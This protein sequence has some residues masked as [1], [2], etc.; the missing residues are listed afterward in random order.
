MGVVILQ[1]RRSSWS[2]TFALVVALACLAGTA[3][4]QQT[5]AAARETARTLMDEGDKH[6]DAGNLKA[7][8]KSYEA[9]DTIMKVPTT[10]LEVARAQAALGMLVEARES[11]ARIAQS[12]PKAGEPAPFAAARK[13][14][15]TL[16][17]ELGARIPSV[18]ISINGADPT[19]PL[20]ITIDGANI[21]L[22]EASSGRRV[23][24]GRH[25]IVV[26]SGSVEKQDEINIAERTSKTLTFDL[27]D[28]RTNGTTWSS[29]APRDDAK[30]RARIL[31]FGGFGLAIVGVGVGTVTGAM[32]LSKTSDLEDSCP[33][34]RCPPG[35]QGEI[36]SAKTLGTVSTVAFVAGGIG[37]GAGIVGLVL[38]MSHSK[39][40]PM[41]EPTAIGGV[42]L[43]PV[44]APSYAGLGG[45]F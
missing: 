28:K 23:N 44:L 43:A 32:S 2:L 36:D 31:M 27:D 26:K 38:S 39:N 16:S 9:A 24:P 22:G 34:N 41:G 45:T 8:L 11:L 10:G 21:A 12:T 18:T 37:L 33:A 1:R 13:A 35:S 14:A 20:L 42:R 3:G 5:S 15:D 17:T 19:Q 4:A 40:R 30:A 25:V 6:R 7:A 29:D